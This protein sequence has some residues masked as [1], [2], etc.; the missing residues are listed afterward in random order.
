MNNLI[1][2]AIEA[3]KEDKKDYAIGLLE[4]VLAMQAESPE[5]AKPTLSTTGPS[6]TP[7]VTQQPTDY[8]VPTV[9]GDH[10]AEIA[11]IAAESSNA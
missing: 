4:G 2:K 9:T 11:R 6:F 5:P 8:P 1:T 7:T 3:I 10:L